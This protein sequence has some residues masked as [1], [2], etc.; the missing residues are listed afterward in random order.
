MENRAIISKQVS[1]RLLSLRLSI[2]LP[3]SRYLPLC[4]SGCERLF[5]PT[6]R[7]SASASVAEES[8]P[9]NGSHTVSQLLRDSLASFV[10]GNSV[11]SVEAKRQARINELIS[12]EEDY[13][14][15]LEIVAVIFRDQLF[16]TK[17]I[18]ASDKEVLFSNWDQLIDENQRFVKRLHR[19][20]AR[21]PAVREHGDPEDR[22]QHRVCSRDDGEGVRPLLQPPIEGGK[23][24][25]S[26][27]PAAQQSP[28][29]PPALEETSTGTR[30]DP[31][32]LY[33]H[34][35]DVDPVSE[36]RITYS[37]ELGLAIQQL[38]PGY[39]LQSL[40]QVVPDDD[41]P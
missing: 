24:D 6:H 4:L 39:T 8:V 41:L 31:L 17:A 14:K 36:T 15:D 18:T 26:P 13:V 35:L 32:A 38:K 20:E 1:D 34:S 29:S 40:W 5:T 23:V 10:S 25:R 11:S 19:K 12:T 21:V 28:P 27:A 7:L 22:R 16:G 2:S 30:P 37:S 33:M 9:T 3:V